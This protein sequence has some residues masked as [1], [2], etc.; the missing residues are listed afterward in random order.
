MTSLAWSVCAAPELRLVTE[1]STDKAFALYSPRLSWGEAW[2]ILM[3]N[4]M[5]TIR[6]AR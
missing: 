6:E 2:A 4:K 3:V 5:A 1:V